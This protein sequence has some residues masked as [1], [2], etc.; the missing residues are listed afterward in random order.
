MSPHGS[1]ALYLRLLRHARPYWRA[2]SLAVLAMLIAAAAQ[3][4]IPMILKPVLDESFVEQD[5]SAVAGLTV[6]LV[7]AF[8]VWGFANWARTVAFSAVSQRVLSTFARLMFEKL[9][10]LPIGGPDRPSMPRLMSKF[11][12]D[13]NRIAHAANARSSPCS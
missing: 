8:V 12:F 9:M 13:V 4:A 7:L 1:L 5:P 3:P 11:T 6:L 2:F 10:A